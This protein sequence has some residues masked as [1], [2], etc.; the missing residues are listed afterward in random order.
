MKVLTIRTFFQ[1]KMFTM[2]QKSQRPNDD[3]VFSKFQVF[4][5]TN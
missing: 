5:Y 2:S 1:I 3:A 4:F